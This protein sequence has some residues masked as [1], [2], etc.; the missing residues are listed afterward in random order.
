MKKFKIF[1]SKNTLFETNIFLNIFYNYNMADV[2]QA[3]RLASENKEN[4]LNTRDLR[5]VFLE[6][7][8]F[9]KLNPKRILGEHQYGFYNR[10]IVGGWKEIPNFNS[11]TRY[12][13]ALVDLNSGK[14]YKVLRSPMDIL[15]FRDGKLKLDS[16]KYYLGKVY[17]FTVDQV[18]FATFRLGNQTLIL[19]RSPGT[20]GH[21]LPLTEDRLRELGRK[22]YLDL[23]KIGYK[24]HKIEG[25]NVYL[26]EIT[27]LDP[28]VEVRVIEYDKLTKLE[29]LL[30]QLSFTKQSNSS[31]SDQKKDK[32]YE[33][34][35][36]GERMQDKA[37]STQSKGQGTQQ[38]K[39][40]S[41]LASQG[42]KKGPDK[43][44]GQQERPEAKK[45]Q[46]LD[47]RQT[48]GQS[49]TGKNKT[50]LVEQPS[51]KEKA[52]EL[53]RQGERMQYDKPISASPDQKLEVQPSEKE[54]SYQLY[55]EGERMQYDKSV[56]PSP[57]QKLEVQS[58]KESEKEKAYELYRQGE[59]MQYDKPISTSP[60]QKLEVQPSVKEKNEQPTT[61][62]NQKLEVKVKPSVKEKNEQR[63][64]LIDNY[65][66]EF[67]LNRQ[68]STN[69]QPSEKEKAYELYRQGERMQYDKSVSPS[70]DQKLEVQ[71]S[72]KEK[73]NVGTITQPVV[74]QDQIE[75][76]KQ[77]LREIEMRESQISS[78]MIGYQKLLERGYEVRLEQ[79][80][81]YVESIQS[82]PEEFGPKFRSAL[83]QLL[84]DIR[85]NSV[86]TSSGFIQFM[87]KTKETELP[88]QSKS[89]N[90]QSQTGDN[91]S[92]SSKQLIEQPTTKPNQKLEV[93]PSAKEE[94]M[95][96]IQTK[97]ELES[98]TT[99][100]QETQILIDRVEDIIQQI[101]STYDSDLITERRNEIIQRINRLT[102]N[103][104]KALLEIISKLDKLK[105]IDREVLLDIIANP[106]G[107]NMQ[108]FETFAKR[109]GEINQE[110]KDFYYLVRLFYENLTEQQYLGM[111]KYYFRGE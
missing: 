79:Y 43:A 61:K 18:E 76:A 100:N 48:S 108:E 8:S 70:P 98:Q 101:R 4:K 5:G 60:D 10:S 55:R 51:E 21:W 83:E 50:G 56:S 35:R 13:E 16:N 74:S 66:K 75:Q 9:D 67:E 38:G 104:V 29:D 54:K 73:D 22:G 85:S 11:F 28:K 80:L 111:M 103:E 3:D 6:E 15:E 37:V 96:D 71:P 41:V 14:Q 58:E 36:E 34:Y 26:V 59:R 7:Y 40:T 25:T 52:Y 107:V 78:L 105:E 2:N 99:T 12:G 32:A 90:T 1:I 57:D 24:T 93:K 92:D 109:E 81:A 64:K 47:T 95:E 30:K 19:Y 45:D 97:P 94:I 23:S 39:D 110:L 106:D 53:Y 88:P 27:K 68:V 65:P 62:P 84:K 63:D 86:K 91:K 42:Q 77:Y 102:P 33:L 20:E 69:E 89:D 72:E 49:Q 17:H 82:T 46:R 31:S 44:S 87:E